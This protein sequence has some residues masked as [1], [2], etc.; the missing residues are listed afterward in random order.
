MQFE[1]KKGFFVFSTLFFGAC[2]LGF[3]AGVL[4]GRQFP[5]HHYERFGNSSYLLDPATGKI[6]NPF[7]DPNETTNI[8]DHPAT[9][10]NPIDR[11]L[12]ASNPTQSDNVP[13]CGK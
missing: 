13:A 4:T 11:A 3:G 9:S 8:F 1:G 12:T 7:K 5:A 2:S 6:C 10:N